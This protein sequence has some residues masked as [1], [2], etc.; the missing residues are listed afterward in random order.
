MA[1]DFHDLK[2]VKEYQAGVISEHL[3]LRPKLL[4]VLGSL[5]GLKVADLGCGDG[6]YSNIFARRGAIVIAIDA[7]KHQIALAK[8]R[9]AHPRVAYHIG[10]VARCS[11]MTRA[12][13]DIVL[14]NMIVPDL[15]SKAKLAKILREAA[16]I[17]KPGG[18]LLL[19]TLHPLFLAKEQDLFDKAI[20][21]DFK[22]Y[23]KEGHSYAARAKTFGGGSVNFKETHFSIEFL[24]RSLERQGILIRKVAESSQRPNRGMLIPKYLIF[25][26]KR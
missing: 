13:M 14:L 23:F 18:R 25:D 15:S 11:F 4:R 1:T 8:T 20:K 24:T 10:D 6:R 12:S 3:T 22:K 21:F 5:K 17:L 9:Y 19:S 26:C 7:S 2:T 16:R